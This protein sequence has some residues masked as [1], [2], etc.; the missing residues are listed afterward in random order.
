VRK[1][2]TV[3]EMVQLPKI[4][5]G[6]AIDSVMLRSGIGV[7]SVGTPAVVGWIVIWLVGPPCS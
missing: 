3:E 2:V 7:I 6:D 5:T 1:P 4:L